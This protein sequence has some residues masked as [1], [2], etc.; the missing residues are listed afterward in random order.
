MK[1]IPVDECPA[2]IYLDVA[3]TKAQYHGEHLVIDFKHRLFSTSD[4]AI[5]CIKLSRYSTDIAA[6]WELVEILYRQAEEW[7][8][9]ARDSSGNYWAGVIGSVSDWDWWKYSSVAGTVPLAITRAYLKA[10]GVEFVEVPEEL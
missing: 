4:R 3:V 10:K 6:A 5:S 9:I 7:I 8:S 2:G 1:Q